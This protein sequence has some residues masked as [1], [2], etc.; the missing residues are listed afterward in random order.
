MKKKDVRNTARHTI[1]TETAESA[2]ACEIR[3]SIDEMEH[4]LAEL[5]RDIA[6]A[7]KGEKGEMS[8]IA[9][10]NF[11]QMRDDIVDMIAS[12]KELYKTLLESEA[13][14]RQLEEESK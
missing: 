14:E 3:E 13:L 9:L 8:K 5:D 10:E 2:E 12:T 7:R 11:L 4:E 6:E 1:M